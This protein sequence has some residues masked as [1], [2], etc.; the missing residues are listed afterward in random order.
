[1][2]LLLLTLTILPHAHAAGAKKA[3]VYA[4]AAFVFPSPDETTEI[5]K[6]LKRDTEVE[7]LD[8]KVDELDRLWYK[9]RDAS[10]DSGWVDSHDLKILSADDSGKA[11]KALNGY[12]SKKVSISKLVH[13]RRICRH[14]YV[15]C[16]SKGCPGP[17][18]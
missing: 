9:L 18:R 14:G 10:G 12:Q 6:L 3:V 1:M 17:S 5:V 4:R 15:I 16:R 7:L 11:G 13:Q 2:L 8:K